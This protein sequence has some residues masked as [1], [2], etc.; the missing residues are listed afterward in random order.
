MKNLNSDNNRSVNTYRKDQ[1][2]ELKKKSRNKKYKN[3]LIA[4]LIVA[5]VLFFALSA[6]YD[7][8]FVI[9]KITVE[10]AEY[11][12]K[13]AEDIA[14]IIGIEKGMH[15]YSF[16]ASK[17]KEKAV[18]S[19]SQFDSVQILRK[20][21]DTVVLKVEK[22]VPEIYITAG[23]DSYTLSKKLRVIERISD[24]SLAE[25]LS[26][27]YVK[28]SNVENC[29]TGKFLEVSD[30]TD[31]ILTELLSVLDEEKI[32]SDVSMIDLENKFNISFL[33]KQRFT[34]KLGSAENITIKVRFMKSIAEK[35]REN[36]SGY[37]DVSDENLREGKFKPY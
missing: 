5:A 37:I 21:P 24:A 26:L 31:K 8:A 28:L 36:D 18:Y 22:A 30:G 6:L 13:E 19:L 11:T 15:L 23:G 12:E 35:V 9:D 34:V 1:L 3:R 25:A 20:M 14:K 29:V 32:Y 2:P 10:G 33:Y 27:K 7:K 16:N 4:F 17:A